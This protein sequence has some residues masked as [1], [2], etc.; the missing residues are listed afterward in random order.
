MG[1]FPPATIGEVSPHRD[2]R[3]NKLSDNDQ[4]HRYATYG[5][6]KEYTT[7]AVQNEIDAYILA[8]K[9]YFPRFP[10]S[11]SSARG[12]TSGTLILSLAEEFEQDKRQWEG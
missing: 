2:P 11:N 5:L 10:E 9:F 6:T 3:H 7:K 4:S 12:K 1:L 8:G